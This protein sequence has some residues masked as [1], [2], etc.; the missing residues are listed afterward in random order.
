MPLQQKDNKLV[1]WNLVVIIIE[2]TFSRCMKL[3]ITRLHL[4]Y[5][6]AVFLLTYSDAVFG[7]L[8]GVVVRASDS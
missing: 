8:G 6:P 3:H 5:L 2:N 7:W 1:V 4:F